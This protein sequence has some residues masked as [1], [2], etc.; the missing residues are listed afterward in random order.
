M[1]S[2]ESIR[3]AQAED[4]A[5][6]GSAAE[7]VRS[8]W[9]RL[10]ALAAEAPTRARWDCA[11][12]C[13]ACCRLKVFVHPL[14]ADALTALLRAD[15]S[16]AARAALA[17]RIDETA[18]LGRDLEAGAWRRARLA[19]AFLDETDRCRIYDVRPV[20][21]RAHVSR[22]VRA[23]EEPSAPVPLDDWLAKAA[24]AVLHGLG[25]AAP[26]EELHAALARRLG[27][28]EPGA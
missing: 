24:E 6:A 2:L 5:A 17:R 11:A 1:A 26:R 4:T 9:A 3:F 13:A 21:C 23:C 27:A 25:E 28:A 19:C 22:D 8:A 16:A 7:A 14:E 12:G 15:L 18:R 10:D 20:K